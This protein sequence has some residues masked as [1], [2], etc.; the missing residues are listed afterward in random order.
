ML[1]LCDAFLCK[2]LLLI[3]L[4]H[5][6]EPLLLDYSV[7]FLLGRLVDAIEDLHVV[8]FA[9]VKLLSLPSFRLGRVP[10]TWAHFTKAEV[11]HFNN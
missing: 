3:L 9:V 2:C 5:H 10:G 8:V 11:F 7:N 6:H 1:D 4:L